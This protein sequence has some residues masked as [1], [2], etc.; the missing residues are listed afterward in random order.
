[1][2]HPLRRSKSD[3]RDGVWYGC[4]KTVDAD[5]Q[6]ALLSRR[7]GVTRIGCRN[8][9]IVSG[10]VAWWPGTVGK[11][12]FRVIRR[13]HRAAYDLTRRTGRIK[14]ELFMGKAKAID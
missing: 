6:G 2:V 13:R 3:T 14:G 4:C 8:A 9:P 11:Q 12:A 5:L 1:M 7:I 10:P